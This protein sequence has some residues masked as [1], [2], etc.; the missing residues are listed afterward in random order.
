MGLG[1]A[2]WIFL[3]SLGEKG[4]VLSR[5]YLDGKDLG[6]FLGDFER[7]RAKWEDVLDLCIKESIGVITLEDED[8]P[9]PLKE[10]PFPP[11]C[12]F[13]RGRAEFLNGVSISVVGT[14]KAS[15]YGRTVARSLS[16]GLSEAGVT[17]VSGLARGIDAE[18]HRG[19]LGGR[20]STIAV[21]GSGMK[22]VYPK[23]N[24]GLFK[25]I[26]EEGLV[27][28]PFLP[29]ERPYKWNFPLRN[30]VVAGLS[31]GTLVVECPIKSGAMIT[32]RLALEYGR[33]V[34]A[35]PGNI[36]SGLSQ[37]PN[38]L[39][40]EGAK[41]VTEIEDVLCELPLN[42]QVREDKRLSQREKDILELIKQGI[43]TEE[44]LLD[45]TGL[46]FPELSEVLLSLELKGLLK[47]SFGR[48]H[49]LGG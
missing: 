30:R 21:L 27:I 23:E 43:E 3:S 42:F 34:L 13:F 19:A 35:V 20:G 15:S 11:P 41:V 26:C 31:L 49:Y 10:I 36:T 18:A 48:I 7:D 28:S 17:V 2:F 14:R 38:Y 25:K 6:E 37:G 1:K 47:V 4:W 9:E 46:G 32:A 22:V 24:L 33:E 39:I 5:A 16:Q 8:Y 40:K 12:L 44:E 45:R 29:H